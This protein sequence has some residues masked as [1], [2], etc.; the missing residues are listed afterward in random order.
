MV[1]PS[2]SERLREVW[3]TLCVSR[4]GHPSIIDQ[5]ATGERRME[6]TAR[7]ADAAMETARAAQESSRATAEALATHIAAPT[8]RPFISRLFEAAAITVVSVIAGSLPAALAIGL[9]YQA[10]QLMG[11][12]R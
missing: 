4:H 5:L 3:E 6:D 9:L 12:G 10:G 2:D 7:M 8:E 11:W 1:D